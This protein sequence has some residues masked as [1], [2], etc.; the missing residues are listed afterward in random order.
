MF[1]QG[2]QNVFVRLCKKGWYYCW[3]ELNRHP[4]LST[5]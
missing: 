1:L 2:E 3:Q 5:S 4:L